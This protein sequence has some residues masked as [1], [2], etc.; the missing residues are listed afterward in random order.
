[1]PAL[2]LPNQILSLPAEAANRLLSAANG[3]AA[4]LYLGL[5]RHNNDVQAARKSLEWTDA[6]V[7]AAFEALVKLDLAEGSVQAVAAPEQADTPPTYQRE[8]ILNS[9]RNDQTFQMLSQESEKTLGKPLSITDLQSLYTIYDYLALPAEVILL[10]LRWCEAETAR[11]YGAG[12]PPRMP[13]V[14]RTA[15]YWRRHGID[16]LPAAEDFLAKQQA[17]ISRERQ[18][19]ALLGIQGRAAVTRERQYLSSWIGMDFED[20][21]IRLAYERTV[22]QKGSMNWAYMNSILNRWHNAGLH[23]VAQIE[24]N[25]KPASRTDSKPRQNSKQQQTNFQ[26]S[27]ERIRK[28]ADWLDQFLADQGEQEG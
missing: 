22:F 28:N 6:R 27:A 26:P 14:L 15:F 21:A 11:K 12:H 1:M 25:D 20:E 18:L 9:L 17:L 23:T 7:A 8:D 10:L 4:L 2:L 13:L 3:D 24:A 5:L 16:T 19:L